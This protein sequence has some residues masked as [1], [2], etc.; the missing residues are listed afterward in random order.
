MS[1]PYIFEIQCLNERREIVGVPIHFIAGSRA[2]LTAHV[3]DGHGRSRDN[4][5]LLRRPVARPRHQH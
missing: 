2:G 5:C 4:H 1:V 3:R